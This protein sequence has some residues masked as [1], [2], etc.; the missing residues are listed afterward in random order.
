MKRRKPGLQR[1]WAYVVNSLQK[2]IPSYE[3]A[4]TRISLYADRRMRA[5]VV[6][7]AV[8]RGST[9]LD[10]GSGPGTL[11]KL[12]EA[13]GGQPVLLDASGPM[14]SA[15][16]LE[17]RVQGTFEH[18]PFRDGVFDAVV[19]GFALRDAMDLKSALMQVKRVLKDSGRFAF[20]DLGK[21]DSIAKS[22]MIAAYLLTIPRLIGPATAGRAGLR[23][24]SLF[25]TY[26]LVLNNSE[27]SSALS[28]L[29]EDVSIHETQMGGSI[30]AKCFNFSLTG[31]R[32]FGSGTEEGMRSTR[33]GITAGLRRTR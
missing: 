16:P 1:R 22:V 21:P 4:S 6:S 9:V 31:T 33:G 12:V 3:L 5:E 29:F 17:D 19:S 7:F 26:M 24:G 18:L 30:V 25:E 13:A 27:L 23:Y 28:A 11:S 14:L 2:I 10:L 32:R 20:C 8:G 15:A